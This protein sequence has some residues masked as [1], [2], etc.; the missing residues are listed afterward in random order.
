MSHW[1]RLSDACGEPVV[2]LSVPMNELRALGLRPYQLRRARK[3]D[4]VV[5]PAWTGTSM[6]AAS[7]AHQRS[8]R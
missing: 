4:R 6:L 3:H 8:G 2:C 1:H 5:L 7:A